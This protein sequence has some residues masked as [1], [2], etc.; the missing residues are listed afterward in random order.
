MLG[1][2]RGWLL[3]RHRRRPLATIGETYRSLERGFAEHARDIA[4][5]PRYRAF[6]SDAGFG[7]DRS[8]KEYFAEVRRSGAPY[9][10][11][12]YVSA[13]SGNLCLTVS[14]RAAPLLCV[15]LEIE[16]AGLLFF[17]LQFNIAYLG[18]LVLVDCT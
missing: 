3:R 14:A 18:E 16:G 8:T 2:Q 17:A 9:V 6:I 10:A 13:A 4:V 12:F 11:D 15:G 1:P 7:A 5:H